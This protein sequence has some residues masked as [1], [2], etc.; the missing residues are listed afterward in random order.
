MILEG[1]KPTAQLLP[2]P[3]GKMDEATVVFNKM[4]R[5]DH[6][7]WTNMVTG[8]VQSRQA[9]GA[10]D[11]YRK[12]QM[13]G[14]EG[15]DVVTLGKCLS[16]DVV[17]ETSI[18]AMY[19]K[20]GYLEY[21]L[22]VFKKMPTMQY[23]GIKEALSLYSQITNTSLKPDHATFAA[24]LLALSHSGLVN[25]GRLE[26]AYKLIG[27]TNKKSGA[28]VWVALLSGCCNH[29]KPSIGKMAAKVL[30]LNPDDVGIHALV[31]NIFANGN[32]WDEVAAVR[33]LMKDAGKKNVP[34]YSVLDVNGKNHGFLMG[35]ESHHEFEAIAFALDKLDR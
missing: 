10:I 15:D 30:E 32:M 16:K 25:E 1:T 13:A 4:P 35:D 22:R 5:K 23:M 8:F 19:T 11:L 26:E 18:L 14:N 34:G 17:A 31:S 33:K 27:S 6:V 2:W 20:N 24:L 9:S 29:G 12:M 21:A 28:A 3:C 7:C